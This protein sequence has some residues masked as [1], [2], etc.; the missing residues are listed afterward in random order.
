MM[1]QCALVKN[2]EHLRHAP[3]MCVSLGLSQVGT[4]GV[5]RCY[6]T[7]SGFLWVQR[8]GDFECGWHL[9]GQGLRMRTPEAHPALARYI[10]LG[11]FRRHVERHISWVAKDSGGGV[12]SSRPLQRGSGSAAKRSELGR[13]W[14]L[15]FDS[16]QLDPQHRAVR[17]K[18]PADK[19]H[20]RSSQDSNL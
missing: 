9:R 17:A 16:R 18:R 1:L 13:L 19:Q 3:E 5:T 11:S 8:F 10:W 12:S 20:K 4:H 7:Y 6:S 2:L 15:A 14:H